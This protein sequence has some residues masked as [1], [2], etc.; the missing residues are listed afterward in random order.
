MS[1]RGENDYRSS[2]NNKNTENEQNVKKIIR[3]SYGNNI[4]DGKCKK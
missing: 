4:I 1:L 2:P 3:T